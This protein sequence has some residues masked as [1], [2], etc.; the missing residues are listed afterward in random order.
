MNNATTLV[1]AVGMS[2][3]LGGVGIVVATRGSLRRLRESVLTR[4][5]LT[6]V[7]LALIY[8]IPALFGL[9]GAVVLATVLAVQGAREVAPLLGLGGAYRL[10]LLGL[11]GALPTLILLGGGS[12][13]VG[14]VLLVALALPIARGRVEEAGLAARLALAALLIGWTLAQLV[15]LARVGQGWLVLALF[16]TAV[17]DVCAFAA[18]SLLGGPR[19]APRIS[20]GKTW[21]GLA[22]NLAGAALALLL[23]APM[24]PSLGLLPLILIV[25]ALGLGGSFGDLVESTL[26]RQA[27]VKDAGEW[28][29]GFGGLLDRIDSLLAVAPLLAL[30]ATAAWLG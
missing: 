3:G 19:L 29:P 12:W 7:A 21:S 14:L 2:L 18:G 6:W 1:T 5:Y 22:G 20:P 26:K 4:R 8:G 24:L 11:C 13:A 30:L 15:T 9:P 25:A 28:L 16:G 17:G 23:I 10:A 27:G